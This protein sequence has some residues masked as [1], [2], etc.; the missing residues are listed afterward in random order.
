MTATGM[1]KGLWGRLDSHASGR[2]SGDQFCIYVCDRFV[3]G[4]MSQEEIREVSEGSRS[5]DRLTREFI[6]SNLEYRFVTTETGG[7]AREM[8]A[9]IRRD[10]LLDHGRPLLNPLGP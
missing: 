7:E 2:R 3:L 1:S 9:T 10:G 8:E 6:R 4:T 5:L